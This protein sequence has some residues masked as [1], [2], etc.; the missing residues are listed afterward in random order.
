MK[1]QLLLVLMGLGLVACGGGDSGGV[2]G[3]STT[4]PNVTGTYAGSLQWTSTTLGALGAL[5]TR[6]NVA[7]TGAQITVTG[8][9]SGSTITPLSCTIDATGYVTSCV[10]NGPTSYSDSDCG[11]VRATGASGAFRGNT[12]EYVETHTTSWCGDWR[13]SGSLNR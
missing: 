1:K 10:P 7:Q 12:L 5:S 3:P 6:F 9:I 8:T 4:I 2:S 13:I 11:T